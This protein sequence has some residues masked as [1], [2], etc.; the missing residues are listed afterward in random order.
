[1]SIGL[2][3]ILSLVLMLAGIVKGGIGFG[4]PLVAI[5][6]LTQFV[7]VE[8]A[9]ALM[10]LPVVFSNFFL[11]F[12]GQLFAVM[13]RRFW[14][15]II[16]VCVGISLGAYWL[17]GL[18]QRYVFLILGLLVIVFVSLDLMRFS[19]AVSPDLNHCQG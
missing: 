17:T 2:I 5:T 11:G 13:L 19:F 4:L 7:D 14:P 6:V 10:V 3:L 16:S 12:Q 15:A 9:L 1:M 18:D 8:F